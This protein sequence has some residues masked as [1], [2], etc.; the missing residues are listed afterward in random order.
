M[1]AHSFTSF[2]L[3]TVRSQGKQKATDVL[4]LTPQG[5]PNPSRSQQGSTVPTSTSALRGAP[6][7]P[8]KLSTSG[9]QIVTPSTTASDIVGSYVIV[10]VNTSLMILPVQGSSYGFRHR[11]KPRVTQQS[12]ALSE[13]EIHSGPS[14]ARTP[15]TKETSTPLRL[16]C[17]KR[18][19]KFA[20]PASLNARVASYSPVSVSSLPQPTAADEYK[21]FYPRHFLESV[22]GCPRIAFIGTADGGG[23][24]KDDR[25]RRVCFPRLEYNPSQYCHPR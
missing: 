7:T 18:S 17:I 24:K 21:G 5:L 11:N 16:P 8:Q 14:T 15:S 10:S 12:P 9:T 23:L 13:P 20:F 2:D 3:W 1:P 19:P 4:P 25:P 6:V 22:Y